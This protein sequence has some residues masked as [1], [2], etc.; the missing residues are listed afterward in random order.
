MVQGQ[1]TWTALEVAK[2]LVSL[3]TPL[4]ILLLGIW[5]TRLAERFKAVLWANQKIIE[6]RIAVYDELAP[7]IND[8]YCYYSFV[9]NWKELSPPQIVETKRKL[10]KKIYIVAPLFSRGFISL[11]NTFIH[12]C[13]ETYV[14][15][16]HNAKLLTLVVNTNGDRKSAFP[17]NWDKTWDKMFSDPAKCLDKSQIKDGY[18]NLMNCF[19]SELGIGLN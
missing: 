2:L 13:F 14:G 9:G 15:A 17:G 19:S 3:L 4:M 12:L 5:V 11:Y 16:G 18:F 6:K 1:S 8:L 7:L 10:D